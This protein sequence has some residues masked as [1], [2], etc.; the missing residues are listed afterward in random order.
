[1]PVVV[2]GL[3]TIPKGV[4]KG[5]KDLEI[6]EQVETIQTRASLRSARILRRVLET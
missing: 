4:V 5:L 6:S 3:D 2:G 1:M